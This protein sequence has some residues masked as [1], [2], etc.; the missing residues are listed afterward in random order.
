MDNI[1]KELLKLDSKTVYLSDITG[2]EKVYKFN[3]I[4]YKNGDSYFQGVQRFILRESGETSKEYMSEIITDF[5]NLKLMFNTNSTHYA[6]ENTEQSNYIIQILNTLKDRIIHILSHYES[7]YPGN[8]GSL[9]K[10]F[11]NSLSLQ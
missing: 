4:L 7:L 6:N 2:S 10:K 1:Q 5:N 3:G 8:S 11:I 9:K